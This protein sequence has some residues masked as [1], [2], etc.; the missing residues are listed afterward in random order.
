M[1][2]AQTDIRPSLPAR[3]FE[4]ILLIKPSSLGDVIHA[5]PVLD[6]LRTR[7]PAATIDWLIASAFAPLLEGHPLI[8]NLIPFDRRRFGRMARSTSASADFLRF[9]ADLRRRRY[10]LVIDLQ[11][12]FRSGFLAWCT[13]A[14]VRIGFQ[15]AREAARLFYTHRI[16]P[17]HADIH[18]V[19]KNYL[20]ADAL[21]FA[22]HPIRF[23]L[24]LAAQSF[25]Q[26]DRRMSQHTGDH[27]L[28]L[29]VVAPGARWETKLWPTDRFA[30][31]IRELTAF[32]ARCILVGG[33]DESA[34][35]A[36]IA[37]SCPTPPLDL[38]GQT[39]LQ[40]LSAVIL[41]AD[42][43]LCHDSAVAHL[44]AAFNRPLVCLTGPTNPRRTG[45]YDRPHDVLRL[46]LPCSPCYFRKLSQCPHDHRCMRDLC[47][48]DVV[49][50]L[51]NRLR[52]PINS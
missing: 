2:T 33:K 28:P 47:V 3:S 20:V 40:E 16:R 9:A 30:A 27:S 5:L 21:G 37:A 41:R 4:R 6:G 29:I 52:G 11:G 12:L 26:M 42:A 10:D 34:L 14:P 17:P 32:P 1:T 23:P 31:T 44:A 24:E 50:A 46:E 25:D 19:D 36:S 7:F 8:T 48:G 49:N 13:R 39:T 51:R 38:A 43:I 35:C 22:A 18:A 45:P 15:D